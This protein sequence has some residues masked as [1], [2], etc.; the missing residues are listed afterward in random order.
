MKRI[1]DQ[2]S[3]HWCCVRGGNGLFW[4]LLLLAL[5]LWFLA[6][7]LGY[8]SL[9]ISIW[10]IVLILLGIWFLLKRNRCG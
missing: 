2:H 3:W 6:E 10:P 1:K 5:G 4:G 8:I 9:N 7:D